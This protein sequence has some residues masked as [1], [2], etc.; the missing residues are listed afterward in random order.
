METGHS[1]AG[2]VQSDVASK[3]QTWTGTLSL[4]MLKRLFDFPTDTKAV[5]KFSDVNCVLINSVK[6]G[7]SAV[8]LSVMPVIMQTAGIEKWTGLEVLR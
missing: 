3:V 8:S 1:D 7:T 2:K 6:V 5:L 4:L